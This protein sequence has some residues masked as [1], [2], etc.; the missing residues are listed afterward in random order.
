MAGGFRRWNGM[1]RP[2]GMGSGNW[3]SP[4]RPSRRSTK[5]CRK[6]D[7]SAAKQH[8]TALEYAMAKLTATNVAGP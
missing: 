2:V 1:A 7:L 6:N 5:I 3:T 8:V 4:Y